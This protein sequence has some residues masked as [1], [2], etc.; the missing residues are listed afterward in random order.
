MEEGGGPCEVSTPLL[1]RDAGGRL[2]RGEL[3]EYEGAE[4]DGWVE[5][6]NA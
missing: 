5:V 4:A 1:Q 6:A 3:V 2:L